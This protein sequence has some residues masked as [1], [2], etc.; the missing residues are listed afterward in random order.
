M[1]MVELPEWFRE[2]PPGVQVG[3]RDYLREPV[4]RVAALLEVVETQR[5][6]IASRDAELR[7]A[8]AE[9]AALRARLGRRREGQ[10]EDMCDELLAWYRLSRMV[11]A[12]LREIGER[13]GVEE[14]EIIDS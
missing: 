9:A 13:F 3:I 5:R 12:G 8:R 1:M 14:A 10:V 6:I 4:A 7:E 2:L 11:T